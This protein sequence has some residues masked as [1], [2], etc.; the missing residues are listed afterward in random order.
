MKR[1]CASK[2]ETGQRRQGQ[3]EGDHNERGR[4][5]E[6]RAKLS[7][8]A[9]CCRSDPHVASPH[10][11]A[12]PTLCVGTRAG[13]KASWTSLTLNQTFSNASRGCVDPLSPIRIHSPQD[14]EAHPCSPTRDPKTRSLMI[15]SENPTPTGYLS[16]A[17]KGVGALVSGAAE[18][19]LPIVLYL[20]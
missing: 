10:H 14:G 13:C 5:D 9:A 18:M 3:V 11:F 8:D 17:S 6:R 4:E 19:L 1:L 20:D 7:W 2:A 16:S 12:P 15:D